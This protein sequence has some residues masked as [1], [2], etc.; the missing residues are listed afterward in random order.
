MTD[1]AALRRTIE[2]A[3]PG[4]WRSKKGFPKDKFAPKGYRYVD[5]KENGEEGYGTA[6]LTP[7]NADFIAT[8]RTALPDMMV[9]LEE[10][11]LRIE[12]F[13]SRVHRD[14]AIG[15]HWTAAGPMRFD[16]CDAYECKVARD[17]IAQLP[18]AE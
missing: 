11:R 13:A 3:T 2:E 9:L 15:E 6:Q 10:A 8:A 17:L 7:A 14:A 18:E 12:Y 5:W 4:P 16:D 1:W